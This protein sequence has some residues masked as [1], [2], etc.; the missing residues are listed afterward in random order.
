MSNI[1]FIEKS[2]ADKREIKMW[3]YT[4]IG[5]PDD[6]ELVFGV[7][8]VDVDSSERIGAQIL[9]LNK[10]SGKINIIQEQD[11]PGL[12]FDSK[13]RILIEG[14]TP[15]DEINKDEIDWDKAPKGSTWCIIRKNE[16]NYYYSY[17]D[18]WEGIDIRTIKSIHRR[19][20]EK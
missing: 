3:A 5:G 16:T 13:G 8:C 12:Q 15:D 9:F 6:S 4:A 17:K 10:D 11:I 2:D 20:E 18:I 19:P 1:R 7:S 14:Y